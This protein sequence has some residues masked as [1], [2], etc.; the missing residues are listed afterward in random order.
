MIVTSLEHVHEQ[1]ALT[2]ALQAAFDFLRQSA[3]QTLTDGRVAID[4]RAERLLR[5]VEMKRADVF[6]SDVRRERVYRPLV[7]VAVAELVSRGED[8]AGIETDADALLV[9]D[10]RDDSSQLL[11]RAAEA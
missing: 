5:I 6:D 1:V 4:A 9:V 7:I 8:V 3:G 2:P 11:K 10:Q